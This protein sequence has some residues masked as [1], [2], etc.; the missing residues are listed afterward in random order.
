M[1]RFLLLARVL[2][3]CGK[4]NEKQD[5]QADLK[6]DNSLL[7]Y[8]AGGLILPVVLFFVGRFFGPLSLL[9]GGVEPFMATLFLIVAFMLLLMSLMDL[10]S[11]MFLSSDLPYLMSL[12]FSPRQIVFARTL[13]TLKTMVILS[14]LIILPF[15][16]G[17]AVG[18]GGTQP[19]GY[20]IG[21][22]A[23]DLATTVAAVALA[24]ILAILIM[25]VFRIARNRE[26][27][28]VIGALLGFAALIGY[29]F[30]NKSNTALNAET[31][32]E[33]AGAVVS[34]LSGP[35]VAIP[36]I[37]FVTKM[38]AGKD[39]VLNL[40]IVL[41]IT[42]AIAALY[43]FVSDR[44]YLR[45]ALN[46]QDSSSKRRSLGTD[47]MD[48]ACRQRGIL[49]AY[50]R[51]D[52]RL[53][54][55][56]PAYMTNGWLLALAWPVVLLATFFLKDGLPFELPTGDSAEQAEMIRSL[57]TLAG[58]IAVA[59]MAACSTVGLS[60]LAGTLIS[61]EG[62]SFYYLKMVPVSYRLQVFG[63][64]NA[65][66]TIAG[67][68]SVGYEIPAAVVLCATGTVTP[69]C[70]LLCILLTAALVVILVNLEAAHD[71]KKPNLHWESEASIA[72]SNSRGMI[73]WF[74][75]ILLAMILF[76]AM[77]F[78]VVLSL[79]EN[80]VLFATLIA[81][82]L[83]LIAW[84]GAALTERRLNRKSALWLGNIDT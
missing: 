48:R 4:G 39:V 40:L 19:A 8:V 68:G 9:F 60:C 58:S 81:A 78:L 61:R 46:M 35:A 11:N 17:F 59:L 54:F 79:P 50:T 55:R 75:C 2:R 47:A 49:S 7:L 83:V 74:V 43:L 41:A 34:A 5:R 1:K 70:A 21:L 64:R 44:L 12:P 6:G 22:I 72:K 37:P 27:M 28:A 42:A 31:V 13:N 20:W 62:A 29:L 66:L 23:G 24:G 16:V 38:M 25:T 76:L 73:I 82:G 36:V 71:L 53:V 56:N 32:K 15:G 3:K 51:R 10:I 18:S 14:S 30:I 45:A 33:T 65:V 63:K 57:M 26:M 84:G 52:L 77:P 80:P 69:L 67:I